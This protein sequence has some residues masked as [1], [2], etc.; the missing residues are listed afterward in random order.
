MMLG[1]LCWV[2][3]LMRVRRSW[4]ERLGR[5]FINKGK[6]S[7]VQLSKSG[8]S[9]SLMIRLG[10][11]LGCLYGQMSKYCDT[12]SLVLLYHV[13]C[14]VLRRCLLLSVQLRILVFWSFMFENRTR[15]FD[16]KSI[17]GRCLMED[18]AWMC[19]DSVA[20]TRLMSECWWSRCLAVEARMSMLISW[21][22]FF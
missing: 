19:R 16:S 22:F 4:S 3:G 1:T 14:S 21:A 20:E 17:P 7:D 2:G 8:C 18:I 5:W 12:R 6:D 9:N 15:M 11:R 13:R 10:I